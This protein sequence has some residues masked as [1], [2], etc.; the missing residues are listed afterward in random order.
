MSEEDVGEIETETIDY[1]KVPKFE[2]K[3]NPYPVLE[4]SKFSF[5]FP[6]YREQYFKKFW[7]VIKN[8]IDNHGIKCKIDFIKGSIEV[9]TTS[10]MWDPYMIIKARDMMKLIARSVPLEKVSYA[11]KK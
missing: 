3:D 10:K 6:K 9:S 7:S 11:Q 5:L 8:E 2:Q 1:W 4:K